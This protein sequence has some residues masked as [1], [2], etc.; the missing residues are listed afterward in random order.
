MMSSI[1]FSGLRIEKAIV[2]K[3][4]KIAKQI[5]GIRIIVSATVPC[6]WS[7]TIGI[8]FVKDKF[9]SHSSQPW[10]DNKHKGYKPLPTDWDKE[11]LI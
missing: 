3:N 1:V 6:S 5:L 4:I 7:L 8:V 2:L 11:F 10:L 9:N